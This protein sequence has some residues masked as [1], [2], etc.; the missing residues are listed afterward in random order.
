ML[1]RMLVLIGLV[2]TGLLLWLMYS[3]PPSS[4]GAVGVLAVFFLGY[5][6]ILSF[7]TL[8]I[9][10][11][12]SLIRKFMGKSKIARRLAS[13]GLKDAYYY[14]TVIALA[15]VIVISLKSVGGIS[16]YGLL[17]VLLFVILGCLYV[18]KRTA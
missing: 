2:S 7:L 1:I 5:V 9:W 8:L 11:G 15:P 10:S 16:P 3:A 12:V 4:V 17:L 13:F 6:A 18:T 14:S